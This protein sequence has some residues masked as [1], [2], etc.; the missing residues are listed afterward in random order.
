MRYEQVPNVQS[1]QGLRIDRSR[2]EVLDAEHFHHVELGHV[3]AVSHRVPSSIDPL[4]GPVQIDLELANSF[5]KWYRLQTRVDRPTMLSGR[6]LP[7]QN[8]QIQ[9]ESRQFMQSIE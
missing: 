7:I 8:A 1:H 5:L 9:R 3:L 2:P 4:P 6:S